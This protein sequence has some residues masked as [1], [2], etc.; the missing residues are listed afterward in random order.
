[1]NKGIVSAWAVVAVLGAAHVALGDSLKRGTP[2]PRDAKIVVELALTPVTAADGT[3]QV[4]ATLTV[5][6]TGDGPLLVQRPENRKAILFYVSDSRGNIV[7][8]ELRGKADPAFQ[9]LELR[10]GAEMQATFET[11]NFITGTAWFGYDL[12]GGATYHVVAV[13]RPSG[14]D[15]PGFC[16]QEEVIALK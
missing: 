14:I 9:E 16:S 5:K 6:N 10:P 8:P 11:L 1:M 12:K 7:A 3:Q 2:V 15:G 4:A 13:Y